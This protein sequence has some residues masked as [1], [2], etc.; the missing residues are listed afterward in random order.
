MSKDCTDRLHRVGLCLVKAVQY[1]WKRIFVVEE[2]E[3]EFEGLE[4]L[5]KCEF[6]IMNNLDLQNVSKQSTN[7]GWCT[8][9]IGVVR[10]SLIH[11]ISLRF[12]IC[13]EVEAEYDQVTTS[14]Q[15]VADSYVYYCLQK[16]ATA[17]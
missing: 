12:E 15:I 13:I 5:R 10:R 14:T 11:E 8:Y 2:L 6:T 9:P 7:R 1:I 4:W 17:I 16:H 3:Q